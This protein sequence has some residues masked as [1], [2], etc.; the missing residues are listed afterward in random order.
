[1]V[2]IGSV[3]SIILGL[4]AFAVG[5]AVRNE[6]F[7]V[8]SP[9]PLWMIGGGLSIAVMG[10]IVYVRHILRPGTARTD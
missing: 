1:M 10:F 3:A 6:L 7:P 5:L 8:D 4:M 9:I 2:K